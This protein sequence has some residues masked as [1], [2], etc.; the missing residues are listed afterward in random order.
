MYVCCAPF[1]DYEVDPSVPQIVDFLTKMQNFL[2]M[3]VN[4]IYAGLHNQTSACNSFR[5]IP[6]AEQDFSS[7]NFARDRECER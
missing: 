4:G 2:P 5:F 3:M 6:K 1:G 7:Q